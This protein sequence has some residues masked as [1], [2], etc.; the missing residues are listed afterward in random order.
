MPALLPLFGWGHQGSVATVSWPGPRARKR[1]S[2]EVQALPA[3]CPR[4]SA[5]RPGL[6]G[7]QVAWLHPSGDPNP[8]APGE[9]LAG[10][11]WETPLEVEGVWLASSWLSPPGGPAFCLRGETRS[12]T[13]LS[14]ELRPHWLPPLLSG[15]S[16]PRAFA[17]APPPAAHAPL[18]CT[19]QMLPLQGGRSWT[20]HLEQVPRSPCFPHDGCGRL[21]WKPSPSLAGPRFAEQRTD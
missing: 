5:L 3:G 8:D 12:S 10:L 21:P 14:P 11:P 7:C 18:Q 13:G 2:Q 19:P 6:A 20:S 9:S 16:C 4:A 1:Q 17:R 15:S